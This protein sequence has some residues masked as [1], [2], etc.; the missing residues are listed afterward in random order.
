MPPVSLS[1]VVP[2]GDR[3]GASLVR[4]AR[5][6]SGE[7]SSPDVV[8]R[9]VISSG[10]SS[11]SASRADVRRPRLHKSG[12]GGAGVAVV[13]RDDVGRAPYGENGFRPTSQDA[14]R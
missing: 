8:S 6:R 7:R 4:E 9:V 3:A 2:L 11:G 5:W 10:S 12:T 13:D 14:P 1:M